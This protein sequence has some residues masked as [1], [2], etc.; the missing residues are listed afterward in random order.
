LNVG[1]VLLLN[2]G[3]RIAV[4]EVRLPLASECIHNA[5]R[6]KGFATAQCLGTTAISALPSSAASSSQG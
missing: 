5:E 2:S 3:D 4:D 1:A 6:P